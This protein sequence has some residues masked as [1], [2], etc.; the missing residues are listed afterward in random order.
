VTVSPL[1]LVDCN[2][3]YVSCERVFQ[4]E[5]RGRPVVVLSNNDGCVIARSNEAKALGIEM[6][7]PWH[8]HRARF[9][10]AGVIV[11]SSN[12]TLYGDMS[13]RVMNVLSRFTP[14]LEIYSIDE[15]FLGM[16]GFGAQLEA[17]ARALRAAVLQWT[18]IP[19]SIGI[20]PTK[21]LAKVA[22]RFA[23]KDAGSEGVVLLL[24]EAA[25]D[26]ALARMELTDLWGVA[27]RLAARLVA[28]GIATALDLKHGDLRLIRERVGVV[29]MRLA[30]ELRGV[31]CLD[32]ECEA[33]DRKS[34]MASR[35]FGRPVTALAELREAVAAYTTRAAEKL[36][37]QHLATAHLMVFVETNRFKPGEAQHHA[38]RTVQLPVATSDSGKLIGAALAG[39]AAIW[40]DGNRYKKA[41]VM[42]LDLHPASVVQAGLFDQP[43]SERRVTLMRTLDRINL[44]F[45]RD[46]VSFA[47][48]GP[49]QRPWKLRREFLS[50][51]Y[52][53]DWG[54]LL[55]V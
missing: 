38:A 8:L 25:Q 21:T 31:A 41:G 6:G 35:S 11:R 9:A 19:V 33:P 13:S 52:T 18:G 27:G 2:N 7:A 15:A 28:L 12:Y 50:P 23:K 51:R 40:R 14:D 32:L 36:R 3:F 42:L 16:D 10:A 55:R 44:R 49:R 17:Q 26:A 4:P 47:A 22:N 5:L 1:A 53:T 39:L 20:A 24:E 37:R 30:L 34:I 43:D 46:T 54:E 48:A 29:T 45:G